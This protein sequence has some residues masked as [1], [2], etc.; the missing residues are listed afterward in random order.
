[1]VE[2]KSLANH[3]PEIPTGSFESAVR[4]AYTRQSKGNIAYRKYLET[5]KRQSQTHFTTSPI[6]MPISFFKHFKVITGDWRPEA[7]FK[8]SGTTNSGRSQHFMK[9]LKTYNEIAQTIFE[10]FYGPLTDYHLLAL[11]PSYLEQGDSSLIHMVEG[12]IKKTGSVHSGFY[13]EEYEELEKLINSLADDNRK[14]LLFGVSYALLDFAEFLKHPLQSRNLCIM[15]TGGMKGRR[16]EMV[17]E[18]L[19]EQLTTMFGVEVIHSE[20]GMT[21]LT[22]QFY[23]VGHGKFRWPPWCEVLIRD[24]N[25]PFTSLKQGRSGA[26]NIIDLSNINSCCFIETQDLGRLD[27]SGRLEILGRIDHSDVRGCNLMVS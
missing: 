17:R 15:E 23:S 19:H 6:F 13:L 27:S 20:Y 5:L 1:L 10:S 4:Y 8:S 22:S 14:V 2:F 9:D 26:I 11:L 24:I 3:L 16:R 12:F 21:E 18:E 7:V 25:D